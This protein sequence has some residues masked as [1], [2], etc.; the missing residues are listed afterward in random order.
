[1]GGGKDEGIKSVLVRIIYES[2]SSV[3][4]GV[5]VRGEWTYMDSSFREHLRVG[6]VKTPYPPPPPALT[7]KRHGWRSR[8]APSFV[9]LTRDVG[10]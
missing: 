4:H 1:M 5:A 10:T 6:E 3:A 8:C 7:C 2:A 9:S